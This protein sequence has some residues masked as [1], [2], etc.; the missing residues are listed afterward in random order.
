MRFSEVYFIP[1]VTGVN[2]IITFV[3]D[4]TERLSNIFV[5]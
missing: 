4:S 3:F 1:I 5:S 2:K